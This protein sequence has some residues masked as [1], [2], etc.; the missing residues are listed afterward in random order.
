MSAPNTAQAGR[1]LVTR[2]H[3]LG[4]ISLSA[5]R[6][7]KLSHSTKLFTS[8]VRKLFCIPKVDG[9]TGHSL[10]HGYYLLHRFHVICADIVFVSAVKKPEIFAGG[11]GPLRKGCARSSPDS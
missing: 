11:R 4:P 3:P 6:K 2:L 9:I 8:F 10:L 7:K 1:K 5:K